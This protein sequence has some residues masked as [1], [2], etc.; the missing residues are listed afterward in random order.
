MLLVSC[1]RFLSSC[2]RESRV[3]NPFITLW[4]FWS[5]L[6][7]GK[8]LCALEQMIRLL[9]SI[10][11]VWEGVKVL[12]CS[13]AGWLGFRF[14]SECVKWSGASWVDSKRLRD[15]SADM[16]I[17]ACSVANNICSR[18]HPWSTQRGLQTA[19]GSGIFYSLRVRWQ[20]FKSLCGY[21]SWVP[22]SVEESFNTHTL[23]SNCS[24][25]S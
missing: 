13:L 20:N 8:V 10:R 5:N 2:R 1:H 17:Y 12:S 15:P 22:R 3:H 9:E 14:L 18:V 19:Y 4:M 11:T 24:K 21:Q 6:L 7:I 16:K 23:G 25:A